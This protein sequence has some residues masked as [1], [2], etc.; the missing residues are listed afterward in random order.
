MDTVTQ[1]TL[2]AAV[3]EATAGREAA[4]KAPLWGAVFGLLPD[5]DV[6]ANPFLT[7]A[8]ALTF[9]RSLTHS[10]LFIAVVTPLAA[11]L[12]RHFSSD[13]APS[14]RRWAGLVG[15][16]LVTHVALDCLTTYGTQIFWPFSQY[17]VIYGAIFIIDPLYTIPLAAGLLASFRWG[18]GAKA[19]RWA[20]YAGLAL[21][22]AYLLLTVVNKQYI[23]HVF[24][25]NLA[26]KQPTAERFLTTP[27]PFNNV[28]WRGIAE[29]GDGFYVG[30]YS[31]LDPDRSIEFRY[32]PKR[33]DLLGTVHENAFVQRLRRFSRGYFTVRRS[34][35]GTLL[36]HD[37]RFGRNDLGLTAEGEYLF[38]FRLLEDAEGQI[39]GLRQEE[40]PLRLNGP[41]LRQ[42]VAR[43][44]GRT[45]VDGISAVGK[46][47]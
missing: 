2:G 40:P 17:P 27:T 47:K 31:L 28:L 34:E 16:V 32:V 3:G 20:N 25:Q 23:D 30:D 43:I 44:Q 11:Y 12:L 38:T 35:D 36:I 4:N 13:E 14:V 37:L 7:E 9:H 26:R 33:H 15:A 1:I 45:E 22:S 41:L 10:L 6:L 8:Q 42:F 19:R 29:T 21:S 18:A 24:A 39:V 5:L 46:T